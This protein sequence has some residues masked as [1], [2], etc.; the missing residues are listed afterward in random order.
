MIK[1]LS[2]DNVRTLVSSAS[3]KHCALDPS[4]SSLVSDCLDLLLSVIT[5]VINSSLILGYFPQDWKEALVKLLL[6]KAGLA[7]DFDNLRPLSNLKFISKPTDGASRLQ[8]NLRSR[9]DY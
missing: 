1:H 5:K 4:P 6:K 2:E 7:A 8:S 9:Y 3:K